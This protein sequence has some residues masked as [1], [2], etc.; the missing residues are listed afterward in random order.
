[1]TTPGR[2]A[3]RKR[4]VRGTP[5]R[6]EFP[7][8]DLAILKMAAEAAGKPLAQFIVEAARMRAERVLE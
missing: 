3:R 8:A 5:V 6:I 2:R 1:M 4:G 7:H